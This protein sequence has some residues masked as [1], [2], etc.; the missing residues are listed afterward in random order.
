NL[1]TKLDSTSITFY[2][3]INYVI[4]AFSLLIDLIVIFVIFR[5]TPSSSREYRTH[6]LTV[7][8]VI[9]LISTLYLCFFFQPLTTSPLPCIYTHGITVET[10]LQLDTHIA[11]T[12]FVFFIALNAPPL[13]NC[14]IYR[15]QCVVLPGSPFRFSKWKIVVFT[16]FIYIFCLLHGI[17]M[18]VREYSSINYQIC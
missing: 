12:I 13:A 3:T 8:E 9:G 15:H 14:F 5:F 7:M 10:F 16:V 18:F 17:A 1:M 6:L 2:I 4:T 11:F